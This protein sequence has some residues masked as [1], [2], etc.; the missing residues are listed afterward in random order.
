[1]L[2]RK[3]FLLNPGLA[4][5]SAGP[6]ENGFLIGMVFATACGF[7][8]WM[9][10]DPHDISVPVRT[11]PKSN[12]QEF[13]Y[14]DKRHSFDFAP[15]SHHGLKPNS[16]REHAFHCLYHYATRTSPFATRQCGC[17]VDGITGSVRPW[18]ATGQHAD[19]CHGV[20]APRRGAND[21]IF[22][23]V[24]NCNHGCSRMLIWLIE[25]NPVG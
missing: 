1:M 2:R 4:E 23:G 15:R 14:R 7:L 20:M 18:N 22:V 19:N 25:F 11:R 9:Q 3:R 12:A 6:A 24:V 17:A 21:V 8:V 16:C 10:D 5:A 13:G